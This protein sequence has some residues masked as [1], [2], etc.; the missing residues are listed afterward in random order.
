MEEHGLKC[1]GNER[2]GR[3]WNT[4]FQC[5]YNRKAVFEKAWSSLKQC[6]WRKQE[7][8]MVRVEDEIE[9][10]YELTG[11]TSDA[12]FQE[13]AVRRM[14]SLAWRPR[15]ANGPA[16]FRNTARQYAFTDLDYPWRKH[17]TTHN[18]T[19]RLR[20]RARS[21]TAR[22]LRTKRRVCGDRF[23]CCLSCSQC[24]SAKSPCLLPVLRGECPI[25]V[26]PSMPKLADVVLLCQQDLYHVCVWYPKSPC[27]MSPTNKFRCRWWCTQVSVCLQINPYVQVIALIS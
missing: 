25:S 10:V 17:N 13:E 14:Y 11:T 7:L 26:H 3:G 20:L 5:K 6:P 23:L 9:K 12:N 24:I 16:I 8:I 15:R 27:S 19:A 1:R 22:W 21:C 2:A 4:G 18:L